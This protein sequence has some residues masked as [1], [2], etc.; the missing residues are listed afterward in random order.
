[1]IEHRGSVD[2]SDLTPFFA[3]GYGASQLIEAFGAVAASTV[4]N[5]VGNVALPSLEDSFQAHAWR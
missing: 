4:T 2:A 1:M 3:A 5:Y